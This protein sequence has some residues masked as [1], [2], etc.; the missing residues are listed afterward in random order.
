MSRP[1]L[2]TEPAART[3]TSRTDVSVAIVDGRIRVD[4]SAGSPT[5]RPV[6]RP[7]LVST[8][9]RCARIALV[10]DGA[11][12]LA[13][14]HISVTIRVG[15]GARLDLLEPSGTVAY[16]MRGASARWDVDVDL[17]TDAG[18]VWRGEPFVVAAGADV[19]RV[20][21]I[22]LAPGAR[23]GLRETLVLGRYAEPAG[24][25]SQRLDVLRTDGNPILVEDLTLDDGSLTMLTGGRRVVGSVLARGVAVPGAP[26]P[27]RFDLEPADSPVTLMRRLDDHAHT[28]VDHTA[29][30]SVTSAVLGGR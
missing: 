29:W 6:L 4:L 28:A 25:I 11:L 22:S 13:G 27:E 12:L 26:G 3:R 7:I 14:D 30:C 10:P 17:D 20:T 15:P 1:V 23:L 2:T 18:L 19:R 9:E 8:D 24:R 16:D 21:R 5:D